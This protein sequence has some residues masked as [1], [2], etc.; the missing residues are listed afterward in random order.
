MYLKIISIKNSKNK[1]LKNK[2]MQIYIQ[3]L[4]ENKNFENLINELENNYNNLKQDSEF[5]QTNKYS[6]NKINDNILDLKKAI[7]DNDFK[8]IRAHSLKIIE[9]M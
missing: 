5:I 8:K 1:D 7:Q 3:A 2:C 4:N 6:L 9:I